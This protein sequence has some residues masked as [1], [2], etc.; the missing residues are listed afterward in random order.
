ME[1]LLSRLQAAGLRINSTAGSY[2]GAAWHP[3]ADVWLVTATKSSDRSAKELESVQKAASI[4]DDPSRLVLLPSISPANASASLFCTADCTRPIA[5]ARRVSACASS[6]YAP[7]LEVHIGAL[8]GPRWTRV[9]AARRA[10]CCGA[11]WL[12]GQGERESD[13]S[14]V[15]QRQHVRHLPVVFVQR[16]V[17]HAGGGRGEQAL[18]FALRVKVAGVADDHI[19]VAEQHHRRAEHRMQRCDTRARLLQSSNGAD[20]R[21]LDAGDVGDHA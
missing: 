14:G 8:R 10:W 12:F 20:E 3:D 16:Q 18:H 11:V 9:S 21:R 5:E 2:R 1:R 13:G 4:G 15:R 7:D 19:A 6:G 17:H